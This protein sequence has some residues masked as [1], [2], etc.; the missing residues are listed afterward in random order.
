MD[1][2][3]RLKIQAKDPE[4]RG[5]HHSNFFFISLLKGEMAL[6]IFR[7]NNF[8]PQAIQLDLWALIEQVENQPL[9]RRAEKTRGVLIRFPDKTVL[10]AQAEIEK[11]K[12]LVIP[13][14]FRT[15]LCM[16]LGK[17][18]THGPGHYNNVVMP[19]TQFT[20]NGEVCVPEFGG[21]GKKNL[22]HVP[23]SQKMSTK[24]MLCTVPFT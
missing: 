1:V 24:W 20:Q 6:N 3:E 16:R 8:G 5:L 21:I 18:N 11:L 19:G 22:Y 17:S 9:P 10:E 23:V 7:W 12:H 13:A 4:L 2:V 15:G 14:T